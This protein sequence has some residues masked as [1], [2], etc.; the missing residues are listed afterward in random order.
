[1]MSLTNNY[2]VSWLILYLY[3][4]ALFC[5][6]K[7]FL[8]FNVQYEPYKMNLQLLLLIAYSLK[9]Y[10]YCESLSLGCVIFFHVVYVHKISKNFLND[11]CVHD[12]D[13]GLRYSIL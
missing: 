8:D 9:G 6:N 5:V 3:D 7:V 11:P 2:N 1:M 13:D 4:K 10:I 12:H